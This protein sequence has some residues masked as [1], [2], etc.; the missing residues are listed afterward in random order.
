MI[1]TFEIDSRSPDALDQELEGK[2]KE[3]SCKLPSSEVNM[4]A[5]QAG[6]EGQPCLTVVDNFS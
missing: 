5:L 2:F 1:D 3:A 6:C 4:H